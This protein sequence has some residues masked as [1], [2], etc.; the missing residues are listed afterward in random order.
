MITKLAIFSILLIFPSFCTDKQVEQNVED[1]PHPT[2]HQRAQSNDETLQEWEEKMEQFSNKFEKPKALIN[3][4]FC[5]A[6]YTEKQP[7]NKPRKKKLTTTILGPRALNVINSCSKPP[8]SLTNPNENSVTVICDT[9]TKQLLWLDPH[10]LLADE[11]KERIEKFI[12]QS[13]RKMA[14][15]IFDSV[16]D[17]HRYLP[18]KARPFERKLISEMSEHVAV[19]KRDSRRKTPLIYAAEFDDEKAVRKLIQ[20]GANLER[21]DEDGETAL[22]WATR[23]GSESCCKVLLERVFTANKILQKGANI[24]A[25]NKNGSTP[26]MLAAEHGNVKMV[27]LLLESGADTTIENTSGRTAAQAARPNCVEI[28]EAYET[29]SKFM[30]AKKPKSVHKLIL[31]KLLHLYSLPLDV[32][33]KNEI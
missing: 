14:N 12:N 30:N 22:H 18:D 6:I 21:A 20:R 13:D 33:E 4:F 7:D 31:K 17:F 15:D 28:I 26:L 19:I 11:R 32:K 1:T 3:K 10:D 25:K 8:K 23:K 24:N 16:S 29:F 27:N 9:E 5:A 2:T